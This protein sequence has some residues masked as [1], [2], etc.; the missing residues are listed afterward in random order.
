MRKKDRG[1]YV[2]GHEPWTA[3]GIKED[4]FH[5]RVRAETK[6]G[7][8]DGPAHQAK[9]KALDIGSGFVEPE[10]PAPTIVSVAISPAPPVERAAR[11]APSMVYQRPETAAPAA[12]IATINVTLR[13]RV[14]QHDRLR[15]MSFETR[16]SIQDLVSVAVDEYLGRSGF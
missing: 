9:Q 8:I 3:I 10:A 2:E 4:A 14:D 1:K 16:R 5:A 13:S 11:T 7:E 6:R 12:P 15:R